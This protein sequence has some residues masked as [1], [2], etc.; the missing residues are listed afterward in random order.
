MSLAT[1]YVPPTPE[2]LSLWSF[3]HEAS[4]RD[5]VRRIYEV[6]GTNLSSFVLDPFD[7]SDEVEMTAWL[8]THQQMHREMDQSLGISGFDLLGV[9]WSERSSL[10]AWT[11]LHASEHAAA[12]SILGVS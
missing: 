11:I 2:S 3:A 5:I 7:P 12:G 9:D 10:Q 4:H 1:L 6:Y 8:N